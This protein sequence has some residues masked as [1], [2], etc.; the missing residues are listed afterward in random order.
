MS[1]SKAKDF[2]EYSQYISLICKA[3]SHPA[4]VYIINEIIA[5]HGEGVDFKVLTSKIPLAKSTISQ[6]LAF[7]RKMDIIQPNITNSSNY[8]INGKMI[9]TIVQLFQIVANTYEKIPKSIK[10]E[11]RSLNK[12]K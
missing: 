4:R 8:I 5:S 1:F 2:N 7:L 10:K 6:H 12:S 3:M 9:N 11:L